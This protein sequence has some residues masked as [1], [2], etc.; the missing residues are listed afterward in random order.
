MMVSEAASAVAPH[1]SDPRMAT[2][3]DTMLPVCR[4]VGVCPLL[5][6]ILLRL[7]ADVRC[8]MTQLPWLLV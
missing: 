6:A 5:P 2:K 3:M 8:A 1:T 7:G 4:L